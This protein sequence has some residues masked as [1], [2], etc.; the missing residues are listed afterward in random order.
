MIRCAVFVCPC[1]L[2]LIARASARRQRF[3]SA[4]IS[5]MSKQEEAAEI[6]REAVNAKVINFPCLMGLV[7]QNFV[8]LATPGC[9]CFRTHVGLIHSIEM[10][11][12]S[13]KMV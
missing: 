8:D 13:G 10:R 6:I 5:A 7:T 1:R 4:G 12:R 11:N 9:P 3:L 2:P